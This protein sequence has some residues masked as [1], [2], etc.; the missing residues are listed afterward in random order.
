MKEMRK[1]FKSPPRATYP[2]I[3][4]IKHY[5]GKTFNFHLQFLKFEHLMCKFPLFIDLNHTYKP[6]KQYYFII[7]ALVSS[8]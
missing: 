2:S 1:K 8:L 7:I 6:K 4:R 3:N 5:S